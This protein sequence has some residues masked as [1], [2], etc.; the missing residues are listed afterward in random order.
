VKGVLRFTGGGGLQFSVTNPISPFLRFAMGRTQTQWMPAIDVENWPSMSRPAP[1]GL[2]PVNLPP[3]RR[4]FW[5]RESDAERRA[6][7]AEHQERVAAAEKRAMEEWKRSMAAYYKAVYSDPA[8][9]QAAKHLLELQRREP[10]PTGIENLWFYRDKVVSIESD[11][12]ETLR[13]KARDALAIK[14]FILS[15]ERSYEKMKREVEALEN[16]ERLQGVTREPIPESVRL[17]VWQ[18]DKGQCVK[19]G[20]RQRLEFDHIIPI[21]AGGS[22]TERNIQLLCESCNR[23]KGKSI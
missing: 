11:E 17:F 19:C 9:Q 18:R 22:N 23:A 14:H 12:P 16:M 5:R 10:L 21:A 4:S 6:R 8:Y 20:S 1:P 3:S 13:D 7:E 15:R 2:I